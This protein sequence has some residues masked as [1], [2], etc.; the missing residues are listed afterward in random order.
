MIFNSSTIYTQIQVTPVPP[1][2]EQNIESRSSGDHLSLFVS[3]PGPTDERD[4]LS[5]HSEEEWSDRVTDDTSLGQTDV[6]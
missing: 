5:T 4:S 6:S 2:D 3:H 1:K